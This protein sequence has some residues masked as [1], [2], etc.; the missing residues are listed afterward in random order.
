MNR[1][2][3]ALMLMVAATGHAR[4]V[5]NEDALAK[6]REGSFITALP[7]LNYSTDT[8]FGYGARVY[9]HQN[10]TC[11]DSCFAITPYRGEWYLNLFETTNGWTFDCVSVDLPA[12]AGGS[13]RLRSQVIYERDTN[14]NYYGTG[15]A[16]MRPLPG[17]TFSAYQ[18]ALDR[19]QPLGPGS[20][21]GWFN[22]YRLER[23]DAFLQMERQIVG[24]WSVMAG[25]EA[26]HATIGRY[27]GRTVT[28]PGG[29]LIQGPTRLTADAPVGIAGGWANF[30]RAGLS[31]DTRDFEP[32]P[33]HGWFADASG[34]W[35]APWIGSEYPHTRESVTLRRYEEVLPRLVVAWRAAWSATQGTTPLFDA[36]TFGFLDGRTEALGGSWTLRGFK[37]NRFVGPGV[38]LANTELRYDAAETVVWGQQF[39]FTPVAFA[40]AGR[41][42]DRAGSFALVVWKAAAGGGFR[43][44]WNQST[45]LN[46]TVGFS[47]EDMNISIHFGHLF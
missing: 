23:P 1:S 38:A 37:E 39:L 29:A 19:A 3:A 22:K 41:V 26:E 35:S 31:V 30:I 13:W 7:L 20:T 11:E 32:A 46:A 27:D 33:K 21:D 10:G 12:L 42:F 44:A 28:V 45:I 34:E 36:A 43:L 5:L 16:S 14:R 2:V 25:V 9:L 17:G 15:A 18:N 8:G 24:P 6:K 40:D 47:G 4:G